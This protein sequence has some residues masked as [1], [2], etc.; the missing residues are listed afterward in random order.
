MKFLVKPLQ[1]VYSCYAMLLFVL[2]L[3]LITPLV[4]G[5]SFVGKI[6]GGTFIYQICS[7]WGDVWLFMI[8]I[9]HKNIYLEPHDEHRASIFVANH[10]S[11]MDIPVL[12]KTLRQP[13]RVLG[14]I[15]MS[16]IPVFG[17]LYS[18][19]VVMVD[20]T[21]SA[22]RA[23]SVKTLKSY[24]SKGISIVIYPEG[25]F[26]TTGQ[27]LKD[28][29]NGAFRIAIETQTPIKPIVFPYTLDRLHYDSLFSLTPGLSRSVFLEEIPV[30][31]LT[32]NDAD[33]LKEKVY[34]RM[35]E[36]LRKWRTYEAEPVTS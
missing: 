31:G 8:G 23:T 36:E 32:L 5:A 22:N 18:Q 7:V 25:T 14:K 13:V 9:F 4:I 21:S 1:V 16:K 2:C 28:F 10:I 35:D 19:V 30:A 3:L 24:L 17:F 15:E 20:R 27:P 34:Q 29:Y 33:F 12:V 6:K 11:Y 26:N